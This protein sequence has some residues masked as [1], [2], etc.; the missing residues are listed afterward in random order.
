MRHIHYDCIV[1]WAE[2]KQIQ[3]KDHMG[4]WENLVT[5]PGWSTRI[6]YR[7]KPDKVIY[8]IPIFKHSDAGISAGQPRKTQVLIHHEWG[9]T[10][11]D[12]LEIEVEE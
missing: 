5:Q 1:A 2:G 9:L 7:V 4:C 3:F 12:W 11:I 6:E 10:L 8:Y